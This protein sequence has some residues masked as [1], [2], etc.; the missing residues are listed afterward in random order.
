VGAGVALLG[1]IAVVIWMPARARREDL[2]RQHDEYTREWSGRAA[3][4][5]EEGDAVSAAAGRPGGTP[6]P[7]TGEH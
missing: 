6:G 3:P 4:A 5:V 2:E 7:A 1:A